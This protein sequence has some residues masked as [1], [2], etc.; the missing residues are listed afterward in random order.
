MTVLEGIPG[1][2]TVTVYQYRDWRIRQR[3]RTYDAR[4]KRNN[5]Y[6]WEAIPPGK[7]GGQIF[8]RRDLAKQHIDIRWI[9]NTPVD[10]L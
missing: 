9:N 1:V 6:T 4:N 10:A 7:E 8:H 3:F 5:G 2:T